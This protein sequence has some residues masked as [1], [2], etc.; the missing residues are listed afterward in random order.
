MKLNL[1]S[2]FKKVIYDLSI[3]DKLRS[4]SFNSELKKKFK[5]ENF[6]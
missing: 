6:F 2:K 4:A 5:F 3:T 1:K